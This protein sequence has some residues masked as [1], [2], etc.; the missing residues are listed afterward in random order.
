MGTRNEK[1]GENMPSIRIWIPITCLLQGVYTEWMN[2]GKDDKD[3]MMERGMM[4]DGMMEPMEP[5]EVPDYCQTEDFAESDDFYGPLRYEPTKYTPFMPFNHDS[6][7]VIVEYTTT[8]TNI[9]QACR[10]KCL[11]TA[12]CYSYYIDRQL[13]CHSVMGAY[14]QGPRSMNV[15]DS[16]K[17]CANC[18]NRH[19]LS[20]SFHKITEFS[21]KFQTSKS[22][23]ELIDA[24]N[25]QNGAGTDAPLNQ[26]IVTM[27]ANAKSQFVALKTSNGFV[28]GND[29]KWVD[30]VVK[31]RALHSYP[32]FLS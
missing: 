32:I 7:D 18:D 15:Y 10:V 28:D 17:L 22:A 29:W 11:N 19:A 30:F 4:E 13:N 31:T 9:F 12:G 14:T 25:A 8:Q 21:C 3:G 24:L 27:G 23:W 6:N 5:M 26:W 16:G 20:T 1:K 2:D